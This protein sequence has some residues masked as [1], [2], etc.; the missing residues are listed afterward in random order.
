MSIKIKIDRR[1]KDFIFQEILNSKKLIIISPWISEETAKSLLDLTSKNIDITLITTNDSSEFHKRGLKNLISIERKIRKEG[2]D[3]LAKLGILLSI[4]GILL[5]LINLLGIVL[6]ILGF[7]LFLKFRTIFEEIYFPKIKDLIITKERLHAK[8]I[9]TE[10]LIGIGSPNFTHSGLISNIESF[11][12][13]EDE[14][15]YD[16]ILDEIK[17]LVEKLKENSVDYREIFKF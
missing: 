3:I 12:W 2:N 6:F 13:I 10:K 14:E 1:L 5:A 9:L 16:K 8:L 15:A 4:F 17:K 11:A 7:F